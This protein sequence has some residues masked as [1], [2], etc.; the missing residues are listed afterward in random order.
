MLELGCGTGL[1]TRRLLAV[2]PADASLLATDLSPRMIAEAQ[3][4]ITDPRARFLVMD[5]EAPDQAGPF[6]LIVSSLAAQWF[7]DLQGSLARL[8]AL[9]APGGHLL[10]AT[11]GHRTFGQWR[12]A[13]LAQGAQ[14]GIADYPQASEL[15]ALLPG[16]TVESN[17]FDL[18]YADAR[19]FLKALAALGAATPRQGHLPLPPGRLRRIMTALGAPCAITWDILTLDYSK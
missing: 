2:L 11:L 10:I 15:A 8:A 1:L 5:G 7:A 16:C 9:L 12:D 3:A 17:A 18:T 4:A 6:D 19:S 14:S 13:H